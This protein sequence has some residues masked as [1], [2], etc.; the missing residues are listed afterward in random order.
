MITYRVD[1]HDPH[2]H[3]F[4]VT[5]TVSRPQAEQVLSLPVW[6]PGSYMVRE[7]ARH[8]SGLQAEQRGQALALVQR[9][10][11]TWV[12][13]CATNQSL[14]V[15]Y[16][17][18]AFDTSVRTAFLDAQ[19]GFFNGSSLLLKVQGQ[20]SAP[21]RLALQ[22]LPKG[23]EVATA[24]APVKVDSRGQGIYEAADYD[25]L[26]D[27]PV[28]LGQ[29][30][31]GQFTTH[32]VTHALVVV[33]NWPDFDRE[34]LLAD[35]HKICA[36]QI[37]FWHGKK[38]PPFDRY[39]FLLN[40]VD[41]GYGGLEHRNSTA[42]IAARR[43]LPQ[44]G[45]PKESS[46]GY[47]TLLGLI[48]HEYFHTWNVK[49]L[50]PVEF[51]QVDH[52]RENYTELLWFFEGF[53]SYYDDLFL[54][55]TGL[56]DTPRYLKLL[57]KTLSAVLSTP[58]RHVQ[59]VA[60]ASFDA[61]VK[62]YRQDENSVNATISY[63]NKGA[64]IALAMDLLLR[65]GH[66]GTLDD[67]MRLLWQR[68]GGGPVSET[69]VFDALDAVAGSPVH[70]ALKAWVHGTQ[71]PPWQALL[72]RVGISWKAEAPNLAQR[73][74]LKVSESALTGIKVSQVLRG[75]AA[76]AAGVAVG[77]ELLALDGWRLRRLDDAQRILNVSPESTLL[78]CRDQRVLS[79]SLSVLGHE[80]GVQGGVQ[81]SETPL[82]AHPE[83][84]RR[85]A[86]LTP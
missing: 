68:S 83:A 21:H 27:H 59:S 40:A 65:S 3:E 79:L 17:V 28:E 80:G 7:F 56:I 33:G 43:D 77:D 6:I 12:A 38:K 8:L 24:M 1:L 52:S 60:Q 36:A 48:S 18:Y 76:Q 58:G 70:K 42:L 71:D 55:R 37:E 50:R 23:W 30:W 46:D 29:F 64:L 54:L 11:T 32:G 34:R 53:T 49:R 5:L 31:R 35:T 51:T 86:W 57:A 2:A 66:Q 14:V 45:K 10:K 69:D 82:A 72:E 44:L 84:A 19:R 41:E 67:V 74:G 4:Q 61:W 47:V 63:Y 81:L 62:Y 75:G 73:L 15:R 16:R 39:V 9:D 85:K 13:H 25:E 20:E 26:I 78:V 22:R